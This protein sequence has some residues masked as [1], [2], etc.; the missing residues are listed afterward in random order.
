[1]PAGMAPRRRIAALLAGCV[2]LVRS[3]R[4]ASGTAVKFGPPRGAVTHWAHRR[5]HSIAGCRGDDRPHPHPAPE[6]QEREL[7]APLRNRSSSRRTGTRR[8]WHPHATAPH[9]ARTLQTQ[10][11]GRIGI[12]TP[13]QYLSVIFDTGSSN[14]WVTSSQCGSV[15]CHT[16]ASFNASASSTYRKVGYEIQVRFGTG[17]IEG[18]I[19]ED[20]FTLGPALGHAHQ[21]HQHHQGQQQ[22]QHGGQQGADSKATLSPPVLKV[23]GQS[24]GEITKENGQVFMVSGG[25][26]AHTRGQ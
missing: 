20:T 6:C 17:E 23:A 7:R 12:G 24:F 11:V 14:L 8:S 2:W 26:H 9:P 4:Q 15:E 3:A 16:H 22:Q 25:L 19:S 21:H 1:M 5:R 10:Y 13:P 18:F